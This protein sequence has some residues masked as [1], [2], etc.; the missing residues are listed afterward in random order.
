MHKAAKYRFNLNV[1]HPVVFY[2][3]IISTEESV[4]HNTLRVATDLMLKA[5]RASC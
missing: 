5:N 4:K 1:V 3:D 2:N